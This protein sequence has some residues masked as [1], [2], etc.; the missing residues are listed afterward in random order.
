MK[1]FLLP[2][3]FVLYLLANP[4]DGTLAVMWYPSVCKVERYPA[5]RRPLPFW[6]QN[7]TLHGLWPKKQYC[8]V[9]A[10]LKMLDKKGAWKKIPLKIPPSLEELLLRYMPGTISGLHKHEWIKHG[11]CYSSSPEVY[12]LDSIA[13]VEQLNKTPIRDFFVEHRGKRIQTY[14]IRRLFDKVYFKGAGKRVKFVCKDG[15][16]T[17]MY[18]RLKGYL[19]P[20]TPLEQLLRHARPTRRG[21]ARGI[22][23]R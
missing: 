21:C 12:F 20:Q 7:F 17:Q 23:A 15:Y 11:S 13:L 10:R 5:C 8:H 16:L 14:K 4:I 1:K 22:I 19:S 2:F 6:M 3:L 9:P 18:I